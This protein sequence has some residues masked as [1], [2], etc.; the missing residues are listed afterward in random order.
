MPNL[1][2]DNQQKQ[3]GFGLMAITLHWL[4][5]VLTFLLFALGLWM[6][7]LDYYNSWYQIA[8]QWHKNFGVLVAILVLARWLWHLFKPRPEVLASLTSLQYIL[9]TIV[10]ISLDILVLLLAVSGYLMVTA[11]GQGL[12]VF[13]IIMLPAVVQ[14]IANL[15]DQAGLIHYYLAYLIIVLAMGHSLVALKHHYVD[16]DATLLRMLGRK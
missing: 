15:E 14:N 2:K 11:Q 13:D 12:V 9:S 10:H 16:K 8:P 4:I 3:S 5:A 6:V 1:C 7:T